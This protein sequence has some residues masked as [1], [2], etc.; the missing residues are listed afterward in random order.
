MEGGSFSLESKFICDKPLHETNQ[1]ILRIPKTEEEET[2][3]ANDPKAKKPDPKAVQAKP[4]EDKEAHKNKITY[5]VG[6]EGPGIE[7]EIHLV[8]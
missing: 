1:A 2:V 3:R 7:F 6:K 8:Y 4:E 5:E